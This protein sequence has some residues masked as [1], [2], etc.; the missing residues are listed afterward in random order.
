MDLSKLSASDG[1]GEAVRVLVTAVRL[2]A[3]TVLKVNSVSKWPAN[4]TATSGNLLTGGVLDPSTITVFYGHLSGTDIVIDGF[5][6]GYTDNGN[7]VGQVVVIK[8]TT[9][10]QNTLVNSLLVSHNS[11]GTL[12]TGIVTTPKIADASITNAKLSTT[13]GEVGGAWQTWTPTF[14]A[15]GSMTYSAT[16]NEAKYTRVGKT[17]TYVLSVSGS[18]GGTASNQLQFTAPVARLS[19]TANNAVGSGRVDNSDSSSAIVH[20]NGTS[21]TVIAVRRSTSGA[22]A[23]GGGN[24][25]VT[26]QYEAA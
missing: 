23:V 12:K 2:L 24:F 26:G 10:G 21:T 5:A 7:T 13:T 19:T 8:P 20:W 16:A 9:V 25:W 15:S 17:I 14:S 11:D 1:T 18:V 22:F 4:F 3:S 6:P